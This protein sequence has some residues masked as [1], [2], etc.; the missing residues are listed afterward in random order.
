MKIKYPSTDR[1]ILKFAIAH[2][3]L[4]CIIIDQHCS[5]S[6]TKDA[7]RM[8]DKLRRIFPRLA[9]RGRRNSMKKCQPKINTFS[10]CTLPGY[11]FEWDQSV[12]SSSSS[13]SFHYWSSDQKRHWVSERESVLNSRGSSETHLLITRNNDNSEYVNIRELCSSKSILAFWLRVVGGTSFIPSL[14]TS[15]E[16]SHSVSVCLSGDDEQPV[17]PQRNKHQLRTIKSAVPRA[18]H[19]L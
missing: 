1:W 3:P 10:W 19:P 6:T 18:S 17:K 9:S 14:T 13:F 8:I 12:K 7:R 2:I 5:R 15:R 11:I 16:S 4:G